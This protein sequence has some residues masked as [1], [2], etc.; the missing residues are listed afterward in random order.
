MADAGIQCASARSAARFVHR[1]DIQCVPASRLH[2][3]IEHFHHRS[4]SSPVP[5]AAP[6]PSH[7]SISAKRYHPISTIIP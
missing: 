2:T 1:L 5:K 3:K 6:L 4:M 7:I